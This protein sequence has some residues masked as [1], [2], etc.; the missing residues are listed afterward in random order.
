MLKLL[1]CGHT[2]IFSSSHVS[3]YIQNLEWFGPAVLKI[4]RSQSLE[5]NK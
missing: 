4:Y 5:K 2:F 1:G 3:T